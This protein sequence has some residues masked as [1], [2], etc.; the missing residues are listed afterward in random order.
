[1]EEIRAYKLEKYTVITINGHLVKDKI[2]APAKEIRLIGIDFSI[3]ANIFYGFDEEKQLIQIKDNDFDKYIVVFRLLNWSM[4]YEKE[5]YTFRVLRSNKN[6][7]VDLE[8][9]R[10][11]LN[12]FREIPLKS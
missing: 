10:R 1:M 2:I 9:E 12:S 8:D 6:E 7:A 11:F 3:D 5:S 4:E